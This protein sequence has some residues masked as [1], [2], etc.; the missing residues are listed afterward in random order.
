LS[1]H[2][3]QPHFW[4]GKAV[5]TCNSSKAMTQRGKLTCWL[6]FYPQPR[7]PAACSREPQ[8]FAGTPIKELF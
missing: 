3:P 7:N 1:L 4:I 5:V 8:A 2:T 6:E